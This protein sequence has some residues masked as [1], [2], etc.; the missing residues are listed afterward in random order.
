VSGERSGSDRAAVP[1]QRIHP[2]RATLVAEEAVAGLRLG[3]RAPADRPYLVLNMIVTA[4]GAAAVAGRT[5]P[6]DGPA[7]RAVF[8]G[9]R[10]QVDAVMVGAT[11]VAVERYGRLVREPRRRERR[12]AA[13][14][15]PDPLA[16]VVSGH[17]S[18]PADVPLLQDPDSRVLVLTRLEG[19]VGPVA[20]EL[21]YLREPPG[22]S[23][24]APFLGRLR[25]DHGVRSVLCE[26]GPKVNS[27]LLA[28]G[29]V[30]ELFLTV[31]PTLVGG[32][33]S[34]TLVR[35]PLLGVPAE[36]ELVWCLEAGGFLF[37][38]YALRR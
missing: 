23:E 3:D 18:L 35:G 26:G 38:R 13:G 24:L 2:D 19:D 27:A 36:L 34:V 28:E 4:D 7:D 6:L 17:L 12:Q 31:A 33:P 9:L 21:E 5:G 29:L 22:G 11:T 20:A 14:L 30:D 25:S 8:H 16:C 32:T 1:I 15:A 37:L 10:T